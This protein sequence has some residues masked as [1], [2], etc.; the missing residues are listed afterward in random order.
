M[1]SDYAKKEGRRVHMN[2]VPYGCTE[3]NENKNHLIIDN[4]TARAVRMMFTLKDNGESVK[5][6]VEK[7][8]K[9]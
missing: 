6:I 7:L 9:I 4:D 1:L 2:F 8:N 3:S 5:N